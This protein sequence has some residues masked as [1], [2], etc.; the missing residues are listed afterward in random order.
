MARIRVNKRKRKN[1]AFTPS[2]FTYKTINGAKDTK[3]CDC[4]Q[5]ILFS[6]NTFI[7]YLI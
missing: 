7:N 6:H 1:Q 4:P 2:L 3:Y 5:K